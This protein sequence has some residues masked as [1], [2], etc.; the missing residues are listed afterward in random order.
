[1]SSNQI[2]SSKKEDISTK[3]TPEASISS[4]QMPSSKKEGATAKSALNTPIKA[5]QDGEPAS[6]SPVDILYKNFVSVFGNENPRQIF[7]LVWPGTILDYETYKVPKG[8]TGPIP[9]TVQIAQSVLFDQYYPIATITQPDGTRVSDRYKQALEAYGPVPNERL[10]DLQ[11]VIRE[12]LDQKVVVDIDGKPEKVTLLEKFSILQDRWIQEKQKWATV[13]SA[14]YEE[15]KTTGDADW[16]DQFIYWYENN[17]DGYIEAINAAYNRMVADFPLNEFEDALAILDTHDAAALLRAKQDVRNSAIP[18]PPEVGNMFYPTN[19]VP[20]DWGNALKPSSTF[21]DLLAAPEAQQRY[22]DLCIEQLRQQIFAWNAVMAQ[23]PLATKDQI[24]G[25]LEDFNKASD[26][27]YK[28][29][30]DLIKTYTDNTVLAVKT[31]MQYKQGT[32]EEKKKGANNLIDK[33]NK[34][35]TPPG[36]GKPVTDWGQVAEAVGNAQKKLIDDTGSM[37][38]CGQNLGEKASAY[39]KTKAGEG[40]RELIEPV[41]LK[42]NSQLDILIRQ[43]QN[44]DASAGRAIQLNGDGLTSLAGGVSDKPEF[45]SVADAIN[46]QRWSEITLTVKTSDMSASSETSTSFSQ[47]NWNVD[48]FFGS[49]GGESKEASEKFASEFMSADSEIQIGML[50]TKVLIE[51]PWMHPEIF[52]MTKK[53]FKAVDTDVISPSGSAITRGELVS[54]TLGGNVTQAEANKNCVAL[55]NSIFPGYPVAVLLV[56]D[57]TIKL[58]IQANKTKALQ[59]HSERNSNGGGGF[60]CF[61]VSHAESS[62]SDKKSSSSYAMG[63]D[64]VFRIPAPQIMGVWNQILPPD[65]STFL[66]TDDLERTL[67]FKVSEHLMRN[68]PSIKPYSEE[69]PMR[70]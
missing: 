55:N 33:L 24:N 9:A 31:Y 30:N 26:E 70:K 19:T 47:T 69:P 64:Y 16:W 18:V 27:Y 17:A 61:S 41:L 60:L 39:L 50:A 38:S 49:A 40:L 6:M 7:S 8:H 3:N 46:N 35:T 21:T 63:G 65:Q 29:T 53:F 28:A 12:R 2:D 68:V 22:M 10:L 34:E 4:D 32:D 58:K 15:I 67:Q 48:F 62:T 25:A 51:R 14:K 20:G 5:L 1:M 44:F 43:V 11:R 36:D 54:T 57:V 56:K 37:V 13:K 66:N 23:I 45:S 59:E 52:G 42:L